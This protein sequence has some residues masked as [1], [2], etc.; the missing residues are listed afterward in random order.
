[1][2]KTVW[3]L[4]AATLL[5]AMAGLSACKGKGYELEHDF[6]ETDETISYK[7]YSVNWQDYE[8]Q[9]KDRV[10]SFLE[11]KFNVKI[12]ITGASDAMWKDRLSTEIADGKTPDL[13]FA[14]PDTSTITD[15]IRKQVITD[16]DP[17]IE[18]AEATNL[19]TILAAEQY[20]ESTLIDG[21]HFFMPQSVGYTTRIMMVRKDWMKKWNEAPISDGGR[22]KTGEDVY[23]VPSTLSEFTSMLRF[24]R[25][26]DPDGD[27]K[28]NTYGLALSNNFDYVQDFFAT[29]GL[30]P[31]YEK[32]DGGYQLSAFDD[33]YLTMLRWFKEGNDEGYVYSDFYTLTE[34]EALQNFYQGVCG[35]VVSSGDLL[36]DG[37]LN[38][39]GVLHAGEDYHDLVTLIAPPDSDDGAYKGAFK[40]WNFYWGGWCV[41]ATAKEPMRLVRILDYLF[42]PE[43]QKLLVYGVE[44]VHYN[45]VDGKIV[46]NA[47]NRLQDGDHA[48]SYPDAQK[49]NDPSGRYVIGYQLIPC[50][51]T[52]ENGELAINYPYDTAYD[53]DM[54][55]QAY[56]L[57]YRTTPNFNALSTIIA[58]PDIN[59]YN[60][61]VTDHV[62]TYSIDVISGKDEAAAKKTLM[63]RLDSAKYE[64]VLDYINKN[65]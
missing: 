35:V 29:F 37:I 5:V 40:G 44:G 18:R 14:L 61:K 16:L 1:M 30:Q 39:L 26:G 41:S 12:E 10:L 45:T 13:F 50:P 48:F 58:D 31:G 22:A 59:D 49:L 9:P 4:L 32:K 34:G 57:T 33:R 64:T 36:L 25:N 60:S 62:R 19:R 54:M 63:D 43:G 17:Y 55:R 7:F 20:K 46:P 51:Y 24:F 27:G 6:T 21:K 2:K 56:E 15:Y 8:G 23:A 42:S 3:S 38:E 65:N 28:K 52:V 47:A 53:P 11:E